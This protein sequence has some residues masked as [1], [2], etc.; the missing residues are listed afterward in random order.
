MFIRRSRLATAVTAAALGLAATAVSAEEMVIAGDM[1]D[2]SSSNLLSYSNPYTNAFSSAGDGFQKYQRNVS[3]TI[4]FDILDDSLFTFT[5][6]TQGVI[7]DNNLNE[8]FGFVDTENG[9]NSGPVSASW[10]FAIAGQTELGL[11][12]DIGAMGDFEASD[13]F[14]L[15]VSID[16]GSEQV[17]ISSSVDESGSY[18][19]TLAG[20]AVKTLNDP[21][22][23]NGTLLTNVLTTLRAAIDGTGSELTVT[24]TAEANGGGE[25]VALQNLK[26]ISGFE[27]TDNP[28]PVLTEISA[29]Q[30]N[31]D[32]T[33]MYGD[34][35]TIE[36]IVVGDFQRN[37]SEDNG[38]LRGF[39]VQSLTPDS[40]PATSEGIFV[41]DGSNPD[42]D[43]A[44]GDIVQVSGTVSEFGG[45]TQV[46]AAEVAIVE[47]GAELPEPVAVTLPVSD[48]AVL[49]AVE[50]MRVVL[51]QP[52]LISEYFNFDR[53]GEMVL[54]LPLSEE[55]RL[56]TP[57]AAELP[58]SSAYETRV[59]ANQQAKILIDDGRTAQNPDP[60]IHPNG[61]E[62]TLE[63]RFRGGD[64]VQFVTGVMHDA[65]GSHRIQPTQGAQYFETNPRPAVPVV[66]DSR[67]RVA[68]FNVLNYFTTL[69]ENGNICGPT[70]GGC[71]GADNAEEFTRQRDKIIAAISQIDADVVG[72]IEIENNESASLQDLTTGLNDVMGAGTYAF[73]DT[74]LIG[75]DAIKVGLIYKPAVVSLRGEFAVL[76]GTVDSRF[77]DDLNRPVLLQ[78][79]RELNEGGVVS[80]AVGHLKSKGSDCEDY[81]DPDMLDGQ[82][83]CNGVR[84]DAALALAEWLASDPTGSGDPDVLVI[85]DLNSYDKEDP[86]A[87]LTDAGM[88]DM[89]AAFGGEFAY[90]Y[91]FDGQIG[92]LDHALA[93]SVLS[94][95]V[96]GTDVWHINAD[97]PDI[98]DYD[99]SFKKAAQDALYAPDAF[100]SSDHDPVIISLNLNVVPEDKAQCKKGGWQ[101]LF[102]HDGSTFKNQ[103]LCIRYV[104]TGK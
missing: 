64:T 74:G 23:A 63:N 58:G 22:S 89:V 93:T 10:T 60:A 69:D 57:T 17:L 5:R 2:S 46:S 65:Y 1:V 101:S 41:F 15:S 44:P 35:V 50:G 82:G 81:G 55:P 38:D 95:Q 47:R 92:Y 12:V 71:R 78:T 98:L 6:D 84:T 27:D 52:L 4:P 75:T 30:G 56:I 86:I 25:A 102:R 66:A 36:G 68:S 96:A 31:G 80:V 19:Y 67:L 97:E 24:L 83:N 73:V 45:M 26:I 3:A 33:P 29:I 76:D 103:G 48:D 40:D 42:V 32:S 85:G 11:S 91:V 49:E 34:S 51:P 59:M 18:D 77:I 13:K 94:G 62:F 88:T 87:A 39:F 61:E 7:D 104:N 21:M 79:F 99:T 8:F 16:G 72:L 53:F 43:V 28:G 90:S 14:Q 100:R 70:D 54:S 9:D 37:D 20:G